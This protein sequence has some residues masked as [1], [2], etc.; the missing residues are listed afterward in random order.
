MVQCS[1][2]T[3]ADVKYIQSLQDANREAVGHL[4]PARIEQQVF[5]RKVTI[6]RINGD[7]FGYMLCHGKADLIVSQACIQYDARRRLY[8]ARLSEFTFGVF[9][10][11]RIRLR[12]AADLEANLFWRAMGF[13]CV[14]SISGGRRRGRTL[15][16]WMRWEGPNLF[17]LDDIANRP[18]GQIRI[19]CKYDTTDFL[20]GIPDGFTSGGVLDKLT[21]KTDY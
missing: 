12:C 6:G 9:S 20:V 3:D 15:N 1:I 21:W 16:I 13:V 17:E 11:S 4:P 18:I 2:A 7:P 8:G 14:G 19:D 5:K 10:P